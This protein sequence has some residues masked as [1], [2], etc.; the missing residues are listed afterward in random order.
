MKRINL[1][2]LLISIACAVSAQ[3][4]GNGY[5]VTATSTNAPCSA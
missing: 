5:A 3:Q 1:F 2:F 4:V